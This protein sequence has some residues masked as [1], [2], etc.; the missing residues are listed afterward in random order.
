MNPRVENNS[1]NQGLRVQRLKQLT[2]QPTKKSCVAG[3]MKVEQLTNNIGKP[4]FFSKNLSRLP[5]VHPG[6]VK[7]VWFPMNLNEEGCI[8]LCLLFGIYIR[9][10]SITLIFARTNYLRRSNR[11]RGFGAN[12]SIIAQ[13]FLW[14]RN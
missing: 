8:A 1:A 2:N 9:V 13:H 11:A 14:N 5:S 12:L 3:L 10:E 6:L 4:L 7:G